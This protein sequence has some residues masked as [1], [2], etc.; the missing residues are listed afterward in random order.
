MEKLIENEYATLVCYPKQKIVHHTF[1]Q[2]INGRAFREVMGKGADAFIE[3]RCTKWLSD[4]RNNPALKKEDS[5]W[6]QKFWENRILNAGW[7]YWA[8][9]MPENA[10]GKLTM[11]AIIQRYNDRG[12]VV[13][14]FNSHSEA[15]LWLEMQN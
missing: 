3:H 8:L 11:R 6:G 13:E 10:V 9:V 2:F 5:D 12:V 7:K 14:V 4:D 15:M 1:H